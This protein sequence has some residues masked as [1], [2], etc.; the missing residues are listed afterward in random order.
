MNAKDLIKAGQLTAAR[1][2][3]IEAVK[4]SPTDLNSR[5]LLFQV[6]A[7]CGE[8]EKARRHL[9]IIASQDATREAG[10]QVYLNLVEAEAER[11]EVFH[12][13]KQPSYL[14]GAPVYSELYESVRQRLAN[15]EFNKAK[16]VFSQINE[17]RPQIS[18]TLNDNPFVGF[19]DTDSQFSFFLEAFVYERYVWL[20]FEYIRE[21]TI[22]MPKTFFDLLWIASQITTWEGLTLN[23][24]L[25]VLYPESFLNEDD[26]LKLGRMTDWVSMNGGLLKGTGQH[27]FRVG[28]DEVGI[29]EIREMIFKF[30]DSE[31]KDETDH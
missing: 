27:V 2:E 6:L 28:E 10:V 13:Q 4:S 7:F 9:E 16:S 11:L 8:W 12:Y 31:K 15:K 3:L 29:L 5:T 18:G 19:S 1:N 14:P 26:R 25:P 30:P 21:L 24:Y 20:P 17:R 23:C 22:S